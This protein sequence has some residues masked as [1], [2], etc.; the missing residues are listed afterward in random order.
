MRGETS[1]GG[2]DG[3]VEVASLGSIS[4]TAHG[5]A[6][7]THLLIGEGGA[8][9][10]GGH[11]G[12]CAC[13][14]SYL[15]ACSLSTQQAARQLLHFHFHEHRSESSRCS[16]ACPLC[17]CSPEVGGSHLPFR[18]HVCAF[19]SCVH[20]QDVGLI[21]EHTTEEVSCVNNSTSR[22]LFALAA[23]RNQIQSNII[24]AV[25]SLYRRL[26]PAPKE[27]EAGGARGGA[28][29]L[30]FLVLAAQ[31]SCPF[32]RIPAFDP[33]PLARGLVLVV[34][35][36]GVALARAVVPAV[37][38]VQGSG[39]RVQGSGFRVQGPGFRVQGPGSRVEMHVSPPL[40][41]C[42]ATSCALCRAS[43]CNRSGSLLP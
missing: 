6:G 37:Q 24:R 26:W 9:R 12:V 7:N 18:G 16:R 39:F 13:V 21:L 4:T 34:G 32:R 3:E 11:E 36:L 8:L 43:P 1:C 22:L 29:F 5:C 15:G 30:V 20:A 41:Q 17:G 40:A 38:C 23:R 35:R 27:H 19:I 2:R 31:V 14:G 25:V 42:L 33:Q 10:C 28:P